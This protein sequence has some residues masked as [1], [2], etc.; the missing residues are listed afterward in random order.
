MININNNRWNELT[1]SDIEEVLSGYDGESFFFEFKEDRVSNQKL[2]QEISA[3]ANTYGGYIFLGIEDDKEIGGCEQWD[4]QRIHA[5]IHDSI[6]PTPSFD[7]RRFLIRGQTVYVIKIEEGPLPPY[8]VK[9]NGAI[10]VRV[11]SGSYRITDSYTLTQLYNKRHDQEERVKAKIEFKDINDIIPQ[12]LYAYIDVGFS[13]TCSE[14]TYLQ[15]HFYDI[16]FEKI[17]KGT[18]KINAYSISRVGN[19]YMFTIGAIAQTDEND[20][21]PQIGV[22]LHNYLIV[23]F[24]GSVSYRIPLF[25][26]RNDNRVD[27]SIV[28]MV[29]E[30]FKDIYAFLCGNDFCNIF[31]HAQKYQSLKVR[32]Q[33]IPIYDFLRHCE[34]VSGFSFRDELVNHRVK[35]GEN[36]IV[37]DNRIPFAGYE[38]I[39]RRWFDEYKTEYD[40]T[41]LINALFGSEYRDLGYI[42]PIQVEKT[43]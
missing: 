19:A 43:Y 18:G 9:K 24:D 1:G 33:F 20:T 23:Y 21:D 39:D 40:Q 8:V 13:V 42:D 7:V 3:F 28:S 15:N 2:S 36:L 41:S 12:N 22:G 14:E 35:Y 26:S 27:I 11:S 30:K 17:S 16:D 37:Q 38:L 29:I 4:E 6:T 10:Y 5:V 25:S 32:K 34:D 31:V